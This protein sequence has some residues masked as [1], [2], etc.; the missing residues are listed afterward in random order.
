LQ[1]GPLKTDHPTLSI[2]ISE[3]GGGRMLRGSCFYEDFIKTV[4]TINA[5]WSATCKPSLSATLST[6]FFASTADRHT[7]AYRTLQ[8]GLWRGSPGGR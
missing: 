7:P 2:V 8:T 4:L 3:R 1:P 5:N 6:E